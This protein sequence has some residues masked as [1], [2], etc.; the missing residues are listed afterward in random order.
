MKAEFFLTWPDKRLSPNWR[1]H[2]APKA[3]AT[4][5][6]K[7]DAYFAALEAGVRKT[8]AEKVSVKLVFYPP[9][10]RPRDADNIMAAHKAAID[11]IRDAIGIDDS[12][13]EITFSKAG[14]I[15]RNGM[16][17]VTLEWEA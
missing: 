1:G 5:R 2:W 12:K 14:A 9:D 13:F 4:K 15:Q 7:R 10:N 17:K 6:A 11:G 8:E 16:V 3:A